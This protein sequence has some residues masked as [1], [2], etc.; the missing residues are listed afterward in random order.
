MRCPKCGTENVEGK[1]LC[2]ACGARLRASAQGGRALPVR[3][4]DPELR[5][6]VSYDLIR[7][8]WVIVAVIVVGAGL[9]LL[10]K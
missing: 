8:V 7:V 4:S 6:R 2:R 5:R 10:L 3:E 1:I 9:G